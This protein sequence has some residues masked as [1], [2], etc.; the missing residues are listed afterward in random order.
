MARGLFREDKR[1]RTIVTVVI[2]AD[3]AVSLLALTAGRD[4]LVLA[5]PDILFALIMLVILYTPS[6]NTFFRSR[7]RPAQTR[8][9]TSCWVRASRS[10]ATRS[11]ASCCSP[12]AARS[13]VMS[14]VSTQI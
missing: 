3:I 6:A 8:R 5:L 2:V 11:R 1:S 4:S 7:A 14:M 12:D 10:S 9:S 13:S